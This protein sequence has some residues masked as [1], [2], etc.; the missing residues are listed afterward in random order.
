M[1]TKPPRAGPFI[2]GLFCGFVVGG[3]ILM[4]VAVLTLTTLVDRFFRGANLNYGFAAIY[5]LAV[6]LGVWAFLLTR[7]RLTFLAGL[8]F[9][10]SAGLLGLTAL[11]NSLIGGLGNMH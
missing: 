10:A 4:P 6:A 3:V 5:V 2:A 11:C 9:G 8:V 1:A 7:V